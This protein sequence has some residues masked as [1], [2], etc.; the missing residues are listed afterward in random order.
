MGLL[1][2]AEMLKKHSTS[3]QIALLSSVGACTQEE[4]N[5]KARDCNLSPEVLKELDGAAHDLVSGLRSLSEGAASAQLEELRLKPEVE[6][7]L[8]SLISLKVRSSPENKCLVNQ[9]SKQIRLFFQ[10]GDSSLPGKV[11]RFS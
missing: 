5:E 6:I 10:N 7:L 4:I 1:G 9:A 8:R 2:S 11:M 3:L